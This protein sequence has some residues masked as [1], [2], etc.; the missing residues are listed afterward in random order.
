MKNAVMQG[1]KLTSVEFQNNIKANK[2]IELGF[3]YSYNVKYSNNNTCIGEFTAKITDKTNPDEFRITVTGN[4]MFR[5][6]Q[7]TPKEQL[8]LSTYDDIFPYVR[9]FVT[10][11][12]SNAG[13]PPIIIPYID[14]SKKEIYR[15]EMDKNGK[16]APNPDDFIN[17]YADNN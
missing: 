7:D 11:L 9:A 15:V 16:P 12:T 6:K 10:T 17:P 5:F 4:G 13:I 1:F 8:H 2:K 14:I 3:S